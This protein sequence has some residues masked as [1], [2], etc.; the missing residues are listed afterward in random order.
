MTSILSFTKRHWLVLL[1]AAIIL[2]M[3]KNQLLGTYGYSSSR[4]LPSYSS[5][6]YGAMDSVAVAPSL[7]K[8]AFSNNSYQP[9]TQS[10]PTE[11]QNRMVIQDTSLS[12]Q[13]KNVSD[14]IKKITSDAQSFGGYMI[15]SY[16]S[17][18]EEAASGNLSLRI[19]TDKLPQAL[20]TFKK[21]AVKVV[22]ESVSGQDVTD[23]YSDLDTQL[24]ILNQT[25]QK[26]QEIM[27]KATAVSDLLNVEQQLM[28]IQSQIDSVKGR[29]LYLSQSAKLSKVTIYLSTDEMALP[30]APTNEWRPLVVFKE[31][32]RSMVGTIRSLA[33]LV[34]WTAVYL[35][36]IIPIVAVVIILKRKKNK[37]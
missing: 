14:S 4:S 21:S 36:I 8:V 35:P 7:G 24:Q 28:N 37:A 32:V 12:F 27:D 30:Y 10:A 34:I 2:L 18:P 22:S 33:N 5:G 31:A 20:E 25:K 1:L 3:A 13:V 15:N 26:F 19:P 16:L 17:Q 6:S 29:Q 11:T 9:Y 23:Q